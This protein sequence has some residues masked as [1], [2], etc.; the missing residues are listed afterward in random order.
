MIV[1]KD[2]TEDASRV[3]WWGKL[4][5]SVD[6]NVS[7]K[8]YCQPIS[9]SSSTGI[10]PMK[11]GLHEQHFPNNDNIISIVKKSVASEDADFYKLNTGKN[12]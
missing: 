7:D 6:Y 1:Y 8:L 9:M 5:S 10:W 11:D 12:A 2:Q 4:F 3:R